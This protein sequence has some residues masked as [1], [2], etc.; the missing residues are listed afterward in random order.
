MIFTLFSPQEHKHK[1]HGAKIG[2]Q[3]RNVVVKEFVGKWTM[4]VSMMN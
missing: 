3:T 4:L 1:E 2:S